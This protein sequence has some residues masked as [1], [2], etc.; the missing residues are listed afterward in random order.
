MF[1]SNENLN[2]IIKIVEA[3]GATETVKH[4]IKTIRRQISW[5]YDGT[6]GC[7]IDS[8]YEFFTD[9]TCSFFIFSNAIY[10]KGVTRTRKGQEGGILLLLA[11]LLMI[12]AL[13]KR[14][15][16]AGRE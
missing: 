1:I 14:V 13:D 2:D 7:F 11:I 12:K 10:E 8:N 3:L 6:Y 16:K 4:E 15:R 5:S 9:T